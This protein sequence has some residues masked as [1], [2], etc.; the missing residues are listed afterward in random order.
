VQPQGPQSA[1]QPS[2]TA[3]AKR[4]ASEDLEA[5]AGTTKVLRPEIPSNAPPARA[6]SS[7]NYIPGTEAGSGEGELSLP[8]SDDV[9]IDEAWM[10]CL[11]A[12]LSEF[13]DGEYGGGF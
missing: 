3:I 7:Y 12:E 2:S 4:P 5:E 10:E 9:V 8:Q 1:A 11:M 6:L 13:R